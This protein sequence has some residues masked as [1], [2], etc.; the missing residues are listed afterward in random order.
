MDRAAALYKEFIRIC[1]ALNE[2]LQLTPVLYGSLG[3]GK[4]VSRD[5]SPHDI[6]ILVPLVFLEEQWEELQ[7]IVGL[8]GYSLVNVREREFHN[9]DNQ[10][11]FSFVEDLKDFA[12]IDYRN[13]K[14]TD[15][16]GAEYFVLSAADYLK[17]YAKSAEDGYRRTK[18]NQKDIQKIEYLQN[19]E[20]ELT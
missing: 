7:H 11:G 15:D 17:V 2:E 20:E 13:L 6:D 9:G 16:G 10:I 12:D 3:L 8:L 19:L 14:K 5:F 1:T 4:A 18:N